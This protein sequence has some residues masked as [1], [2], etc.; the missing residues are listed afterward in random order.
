MQ[1]QLLDPVGTESV[2]GVVRR[3]GAVPAQPDPAAELAV[4]ARRKRSRPGEVARALAEGLIIKTFAFRGATYLMTAEDAG[5]YLALRS[6]NRTWER[7]GWQSHFELT[8]SDWPVLRDTVREAL[9]DGPLTRDELGTAVTARPKFR[10]LGF[11]FSGQSFT[12]LKPLAWHGVMSFGPPREGRVTFQSLDSNPRWAGVP[13]LDE[14]GMR[15]VEAYFRAYGPA[16]ANHLHYW[17]GAGLGAGRRRIDSW[18]AGFGDRLAPV[19]VNGES[20]YVLREHLEELA[21]TTATTTTRLLPAFDQWVNGP[22]TA[23]PHVVPTA[24]RTLVTRGANIVIAGGVVSGTWSLKD[25]HLVVAWFAEAT[26][27]AR[28]ELEAEVSRLA[29]ILGRPL[30]SAVQMA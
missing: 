13:E 29:T 22:G 30:Q 16:T 7:P 4:R 19:D 14:A 26:P 15:A 2:A 3:L 20:T 9:A 5:S 8:P 17:L 11:A 21:S 1:Q 12:F 10:H 18:I 24:R 6:A 28:E 23:D 27:P 25:D